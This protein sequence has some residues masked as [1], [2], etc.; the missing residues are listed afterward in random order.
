VTEAHQFGHVSTLGDHVRVLRRRKWIVVVTTVLVTAT[1]LFQ[2]SRQTTVYQAYAQVLIGQVNPAMAVIGAV[3]RSDPER[4]SATQAF[5][6]GGPDVSARV[7]ALPEFRGPARVALRGG[8]SVY[9]AANSD[10]LIFQATHSDPRYA[11]AL[12]NAFAEQYLV[13]R[14]QTTT[15][16]MHESRVRIEGQLAKLQS[17]GREGSALYANLADQA[18]SLQIA[19]TLQSA[20]ASLARAATGAVPNGPKP[21][22]DGTLGFV[23]GLMLG[24]GLAFLWSALDTRIRAAAEIGERLGLPLLARVPEPPR[25]LRT[26]RKLVM[27]EAPDSTQAEAFRMLRTNLQFVNLER[28]ARSIMVT[29]GVEEEGKST[30]IANLAI[31]F[32][33]TGKRVVLVDLDLRRPSLAR[34]FGLNGHAGLT[35]IALENVGLDEALATIPIS[36][37]H[38]E[39]DERGR[40]NGNVGIEG[41]LQVLPTGPLPP[42]AGEFMESRVVTQILRDLEARADL[43]LIDAPP[44]LHVGDAMVLT[45]KVDALILVSRLNVV[46]RPMVTELRRLLSTAPAVPLGFVLTGAGDDESYDSAGYYAYRPRRRDREAV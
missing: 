10:L 13:Y 24:V 17:E 27:L 12:A 28:G 22:R 37:P 45:A 43:I 7:A 20:T 8:I 32:A 21:V 3:P 25:K 4:D 9:P 29:S 5:I 41:M 26:Q 36:A 18:Q 23:L 34:F 11:V 46:R 35:D 14:R 15:R 38:E 33:R 6:A 30:T 1:A 44:L 40:F 31:A 2:S 16:S 39:G 19:E 42:D